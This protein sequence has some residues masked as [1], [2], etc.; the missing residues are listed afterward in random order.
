MRFD[1]T[2]LLVEDVTLESLDLGLRR[3]VA[4]ANAV[5]KPQLHVF[6]LNYSFHGW[7]CM[8]QESRFTEVAIGMHETSPIK[9]VEKALEV[10]R[11]RDRN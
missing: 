1:L 3:M 4:A 5:C 7:A 9:A 8:I 2:E 11:E 10:I 6:T